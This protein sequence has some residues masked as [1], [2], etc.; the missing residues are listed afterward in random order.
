MIPENIKTRIS[1]KGKLNK[2][3]E[4]IKKIVKENPDSVY[5]KT[6]LKK[7]RQKFWFG[8][9]HV[10]YYE[11]FTDAWFQIYPKFD[12]DAIE[13]G[14]LKFVD[15]DAFK[16]EYTDIFIAGSVSE[17]LYS[18]N[19][20]IIACKV[21]TLLSDEGPYENKHV[22]LNK[23]DIVIDA[24]ANIGLFSMFCSQKEVEKVYAFEPQKKVVKLL[25]K[26]I[27]LNNL[28]DLIEIIPVGLSDKNEDCSLSH[29]NFGHAAGSI[30]IQRNEIDDIEKIHCITLDNWANENNIT[31]IDFIKAD[32][33]GAERNM[34]SGATEILKK[35]APRLA[36]CT[37]HLPD[38]P[39]VLKNII[40]N[41]NP[42]YVIEQ[43]SHKLF[44]YV[45]H[46]STESN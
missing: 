39:M 15:D 4:F 7:F 32:I 17:S 11:I 43:T 40:V 41:A 38:D 16:A 33:E 21:L 20:K 24:G 35:F 25:E 31:K 19:D 13:I 42:N 18:E 10:H 37:Y 36:I 34:L 28:S 46:H 29:S 45:P 23:D 26:N 1:P 8:S 14:G 30:V 2:Q 22:K 9:S 6:V 27:L 3:L 5:A 12:N 44:A